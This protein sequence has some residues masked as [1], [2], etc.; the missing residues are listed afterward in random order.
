MNRTLSQEV[1]LIK[2]GAQLLWNRLNFN[3]VSVIT[4]CEKV[5][6]YRSKI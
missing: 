4:A 1:N 3:N 5:G 6:S 2:S